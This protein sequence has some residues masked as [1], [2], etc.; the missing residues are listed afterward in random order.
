MKTDA[1]IRR[2]VEEELRFSPDIDE[3]DIAAKVNDGVV[4]LTGYANSY[5]EKYQAEAAAK[6]VA[7][8]AGVANDIQVR[9]SAN[10]LDDPEIARAAVAAIRAELPMSHDNIKVLVHQGHITLEG[11][12]EWHYQKERAEVAA[13][14][15]K[16]VMEL[17]NLIEVAPHISTSDIKHKIEDAFRRNAQIDADRVSI[18]AC[19]SEVTLRGDVRSWAE[20]DEAGRTAWSAPG[21]AQV[22]NE[23]TVRT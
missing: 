16:G 10:V 1:G 18:E 11:T 9:P 17:G 6:R 14:R 15:V 7:G 3:T 8:V 12:V 13:R 23:I 19:G 5:F 20:R 21:V 22:K 2:D 4:T